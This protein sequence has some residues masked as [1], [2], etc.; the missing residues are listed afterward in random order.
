MLVQFPGFSELL[1]RA[2]SS[3]A[4]AR[5]RDRP[6]SNAAARQGCMALRNMAVRCGNSA[7]YIM[8]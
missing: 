7:L 4:A 2:L 1:L 5:A 6:R 8:R 3:S